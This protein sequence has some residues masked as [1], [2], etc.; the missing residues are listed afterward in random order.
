DLIPE[1]NETLTLNLTNAQNAIITISNAVGT[2]LDDDGLPGALHHFEWS[3]I[4]NPQLQ[5]VGFP[6]TITARDFSGAVATNLPWPVRLSAQ[7][8]NVLAAN[9]NFEQ[10]SLAP[11]APFDFTGNNHPAQQVLYDVAGLGQP[12]TAYRTIAG[13][14]TNGITQNIFL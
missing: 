11:W 4:P 10:P 2:I 13:G 3:A 9:L 7:T 12:S 14:G 1:S 8:T 6:V 5:T